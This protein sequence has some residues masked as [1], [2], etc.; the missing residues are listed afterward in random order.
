M[1]RIRS[2]S[3]V[4]PSLFA[5]FA[6]LWISVV[7]SAV[8]AQQVTSEEVFVVREIS[9]DETAESTSAAR[10]QALAKGQITAAQ[11]LMDRLTRP[12]DRSALAPLDAETVRTL[13][14][15]FQIDNEKTSNVRYLADM[16][17]SFKP[18]AVRRFL[19]TFGV[20]FAEVRSR[21]VLI[22]PALARETGY[23]LWEEPNPWREAWQNH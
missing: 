20:P 11:R 14:A 18:A 5:V 23:I 13:V 4:F 10:M 16:T 12:L 9:V 6:M 2:K 8:S 19:Q 17:V 7:P 1:R 21:P 15:S 3:R 22:V